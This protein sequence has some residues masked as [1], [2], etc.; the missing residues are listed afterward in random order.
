VIIELTE[1]GE[2]TLHDDTLPESISFYKLFGFKQKTFTKK[3]KYK[4]S[5]P[6]VYMSIYFLRFNLVNQQHTFYN[7][8]KS[9]ILAIIPSSFKNKTIYEPASCTILSINQ[10]QPKF[11]GRNINYP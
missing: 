3:G 5:L 4:S 11:C 6:L 2:F 10:P 9:D 1:N 8:K 7:N